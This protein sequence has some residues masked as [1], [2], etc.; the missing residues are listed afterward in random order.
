MV[1]NVLK[2]AKGLFINLKDFLTSSSDASDLLTSFSLSSGATS[3]LPTRQLVA[4]HRVP[5][6]HMKLHLVC[7]AVGHHVNPTKMFWKS[8]AYLLSLILCSMPKSCPSYLIDDVKLMGFMNL[9]AYR[10]Y[11]VTETVHREAA[12]FRCCTDQVDCPHKSN[13]CFTCTELT[14]LLE[15][16]HSYVF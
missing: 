10:F 15:N 3:L 2:Q 4:W 6:L 12:H 8:I 7:A 9:E 14:H 16:T 5:D 13:K 1:S 11:M